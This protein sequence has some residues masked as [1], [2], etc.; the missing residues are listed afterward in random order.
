[1]LKSG[2]KSIVVN[3]KLRNFAPDKNMNGVLPLF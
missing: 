3:E 2:R 1:M